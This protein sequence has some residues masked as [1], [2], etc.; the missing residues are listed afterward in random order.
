[1]MET[2]SRF[3]PETQ[4]AMPAHASEMNGMPLVGSQMMTIRSSSKTGSASQSKSRPHN[5]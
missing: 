4:P 3:M 2:P 5:K 1:M